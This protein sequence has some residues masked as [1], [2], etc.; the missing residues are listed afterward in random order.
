MTSASSGS[1]NFRILYFICPYIIVKLLSFLVLKSPHPLANVT[2]L[3]MR[4]LSILLLVLLSAGLGHFLLRKLHVLSECSVY[5]FC[6]S[7]T[8]GFV[9]IA[10]TVFFALIRILGINVFIPL[11]FLALYLSLREISLY[12]PDILPRSPRFRDLGGVTIGI[13]TILCLLFL[14]S[15]Y[16]A[17]TPPRAWDEQVYHL[18]IPRIYLQSRGFLYIPLNVYSNMPLNQQLLYLSAMVIGDDVTARALHYVM[19]L[20]VCLS[21]YGFSRRYLSPFAGVI[22]PLLFLCNPI[23]YSELGIAYIDIG[24]A[25]FCVW[26]VFS[27]V[28]FVRSGNEKYG[29][30]MGLFAGM[31]MGSKYTMVFGFVSGLIVLVLAPVMWTGKK[32]SSPENEVGMNQEGKGNFFKVLVVY[33]FLALVLFFP[34]MMKNYFYTGNPLYPAFYSVFGGRDW[35]AQQSSWLVDWQHSI[36]RGRKATD[37]LLLIF[38]IFIPYEGPYG[39]RGFAGVLYPYMILVLPSILFIKKNRRMILMLLLFFL[40]F[41]IAWSLGAQQ[42]RFLIPG[43]PLLA[44]CS[45][46]GVDSLKHL[47]LKI[48]P[49]MALGIVLLAPLHLG[50]D[51]IYK[52]I[53][54]EGSLFPILMGKESRED[55]LR[56]RVGAYTC[57]EY[58]LSKC[59][60]GEPVLFLFENRGYYCD[61]PYYADSM[62]EASHFLN[63]ALEAGSPQELHKRLLKYNARFVVVDQDIREGI[64]QLGKIWILS[65]EQN[66]DK[67]KKALDIMNRFIEIYL[68]QVFAENRS[69]VYAFK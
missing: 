16:T 27:L 37:Y 46:A 34:W 7:V 57:F 11:I 67:Y 14:Y 61:Q 9:L 42:I 5:H 38:R 2:L 21:L 58:L 66:R 59:Y 43:L 45:A 39:Y 31:G 19:G 28:E 6:F 33:V 68:E 36:G 47:K 18:Q 12:L 44:L 49:W 51:Y 26:I 1:R 15:L 40:V 55:F 13:L 56:P 20:V 53:K 48:V 52:E 65:N 41:F 23:V 25:L 64:V 35:T 50:I 22:A 8:A 17:L 24:M 30:L 3:V 69:T 32:D 60:P 10:Y 63:L 4:L 29:I 54:R 62:Y